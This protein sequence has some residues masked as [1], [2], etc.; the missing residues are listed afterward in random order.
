[1]ILQ[2]PLYSKGGVLAGHY[3]IVIVYVEYYRYALLVCTESYGYYSHCY[4]TIC[5]VIFVM[6][7]HVFILNQN[8]YCKRSISTYIHKCNSTQWPW[9]HWPLQFLWPW[10]VCA[11]HIPRKEWLLY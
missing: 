7:D 9:L 11:V 2:G 10:Y 6:R 5:D 1:M 8:M 3:G 4:C